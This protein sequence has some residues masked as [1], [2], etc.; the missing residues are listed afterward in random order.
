MF[1][2]FIVPAI[3]FAQC[4]GSSTNYCSFDAAQKANPVDPSIC[5]E[6]QKNQNTGIGIVQC[7]RKIICEY[8]VN[9]NKD[10]TYSVNKNLII[11]VADPADACNFNSVMALVNNI[12][13]FILV[14]LALP[15]AAIMFAYA[16]FLLL[17]SAGDTSARTKAKEIFLNA[18]IGLI[19]AF[20][21]YLI[22]MLLLKTLGYTGTWIGF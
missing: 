13:K 3:S 2:M 15:I 21:A 1:L 12:I 18:A 20:C 14:G 11:R 16:G 9:Q 19:I 6:N 8:Q 4:T 10:G 17:T 22:I 7:G 5:S